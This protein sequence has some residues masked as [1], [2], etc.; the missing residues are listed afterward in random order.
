MVPTAEASPRWLQQYA[1]LDLDD[2]REHHGVVCHVRP[3]L[4]GCLTAVVSQRADGQWVAG[5]FTDPESVREVAR[6]DQ[7]VA[8]RI[9]AE[10][11]DGL[12]AATFRP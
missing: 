2:A 9:A 3:D 10:H 11:S 7:R 8:E 1:A 12:T 4:G 6:A 5:L